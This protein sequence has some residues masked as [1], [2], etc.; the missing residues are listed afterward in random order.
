MKT[1]PEK[2]KPLINITI[3][4]IIKD[5]PVS[6]ES[7][8]RAQDGNSILRGCGVVVLTFALALAS[9]EPEEDRST[10][11]YKGRNYAKYLKTE[12]YQQYLDCYALD[13]TLKKQCKVALAASYGDKRLRGDQEYMQVFQEEC[14]KLGFKHF[15][16]SL[17]KPCQ[18]ISDSPL[19]IEDKNAYQIICKPEEQYMMRFDYENKAWHLL[20]DGE[21]K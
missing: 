20:K 5:I 1:D 3:P 9:C 16:N 12:I 4:N 10:A 2:T 19:F 7:F 15:L 17:G 21:S 11:S 18:S 13:E 14:E 6:A 8:A